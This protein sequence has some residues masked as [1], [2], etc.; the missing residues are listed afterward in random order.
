MQEYLIRVVQVHPSFRKAELEALATYAGIEIE[1]VAY[2][3]D[4]PFC[5]VRLPSDDAARALISRSVLSAAIYELW[6]SGSTYED[7]H[8]SIT[9]RTQSRWP[10]YKNDSFRFSVDSFQGKRSNSQQREI[11]DTFRYMG[12]EGPIRMKDPDLHLTIFEHFEMH[13]PEPH[14]I[15]LGRHIA[16]SG[17]RAI[18]KYDLK[19]RCYIST[20]SMDSELALVSA[21]MA[22]AGPGKLF[23]DPFA[24]T[25]SFPVACAHF[26]AMALGADID[27]RSIRGKA[28]KDVLSN[29]KQYGLMDKCLDNCISDLTNTP[30]RKARWLD[31]II[32]DP[33]YGVREGLKVLGRKDEGG[34]EAVII[35]GQY[36]HLR[37]GF[38]PPKKPYSFE[39][40]LDDIME[41][42]T[43]M[44]VDEG[45]LS[46]WMPTANDEDIELAIPT[47]P[48]LE[49]ISVC[50]QP[51]NKWSRRLLTY[52]RIPDALVDK[53]A[54]W[55][56]REFGNGVHADELNSFRRRY[57]QGFKGADEGEDPST[58]VSASAAIDQAA[59]DKIS[60][61]SISE[62]ATQ[63]SK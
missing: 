11:I 37:E 26:G 14:A 41:F 63:P 2:S 31:G 43:D 4:S 49:I 42:A 56:K 33:P 29:F 59:A 1:F 62:D 12:F 15:Y 27:G 21:N 35:D 53:T 10:A 50:I 16:D 6:G 22:L 28:G 60:E 34:K 25:G 9:E 57:F 58:P 54:S 18:V 51:F 55:T 52:R 30:L 44:L 19:K 5:I 3:E 38:I 32:C 39:A 36:A 8:T 45:R 7:L 48:Y 40:M 17:R 20:T 47:H 46:M 61:L 23:F 13:T 24:G